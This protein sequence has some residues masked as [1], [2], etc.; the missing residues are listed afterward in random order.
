[1]L[2]RTRPVLHMSVLVGNVELDYRKD[3][4]KG[5]TRFPVTPFFAYW[6]E[7]ECFGLITNGKDPQREA[8][9]RNSQALHH[10]NQSANSGW[11]MDEGA[12]SNMDALE[13]MGSKPGIIVQKRRGFFLQ[14]ITPT[15]ISEGHLGL[16]EQSYN[17]IKRITG[18]NADLLGQSP[19]RQ[20]CVTPDTECLTKTGFKRYQALSVGEEIYTVN[21]RTL[22]AEWKPVK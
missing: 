5:M 6:L 7:G 22:L 21:P 20:E 10:L 8:N 14:K 16:A 4:Y 1:M 17:A 13:N 19:E 15:P 18:V 3:P 11:V 12:V 9:K 2:T